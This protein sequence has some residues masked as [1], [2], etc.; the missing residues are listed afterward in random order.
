MTGT[1]S[2]TQATPPP[3]HLA[4][5]HSNV[6]HANWMGTHASILF[7]FPAMAI[8]GVVTPYADGGW[9]SISVLTLEDG[10]PT[11]LHMGWTLG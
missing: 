11:D 4:G 5:T 1:T 7:Q 2:T 8:T 10:M 6:R 3:K 9:F